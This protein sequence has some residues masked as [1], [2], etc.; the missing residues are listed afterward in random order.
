[1]TRERKKN[2]HWIFWLL[3]I[4]FVWLIISRHSEVQNLLQALSQGKWLWVLTAALVQLVYYGIRSMLYQSAFDAVDVMSHW[5]S[6]LPLT[7][8]SVFLNVAAPSAGASGAAIFVDDAARR[9]QSPGAATV[10]ALLVLIADF[11]AFLVI[12]SIGLAYLFSVNDLQ[13]YE[14]ITAIL[15]FIITAGWTLVLLLGLWRVSWLHKL[16]LFTQRT[17]NTISS[18]LKRQSFVAEDW[19]ERITE[20]FLE[21]REAINS[22]PIRLV[23]TF[24]IALAAHIIDILSLYC[25]FYAFHQP[26]GFGVLVAGYSMGILFWVVSVT[27]QGI[28]VVEGMM[29][30]VFTSLGI[31]TEPAAIISLTFRGMTFWLPLGIGFILLRRIRAFR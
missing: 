21:A 20:E 2:T 8:S 13:A 23:R 12:L 1:M 7:F 19:A 15:F 9:G 30:L 26:S 31:P 25:L 16:L 11:S 3:V 22:H 10:G 28:G 29:T 24:C 18:Y 6:L 14:I 27:P 4:A 5:W 17:L